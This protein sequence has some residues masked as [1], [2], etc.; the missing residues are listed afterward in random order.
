MKKTLS[1]FILSFTFCIASN[2]YAQ[3]VGIGTTAPVMRLHVQDT[4]SA[5]A[6]LE[7]T[8]PLAVDRGTALYFKTGSYYTGAI[9]TIGTGAALSRLGLF[10]Y[11]VGS[12]NSLREYLSIADNGNVGVGAIDPAYKLDINGR[13]CLRYNGNTAGAWLNKQDNSGAAVFVGNY[14]DSIFGI[15]GTTTG[16]K[17]FFDH[18][19][20]NLGINISNPKVDLSFPAATG[21]KISF[22]PGGSGDVGIGVYGNEF[23]LHS[24]HAGADITFGYDSYTAGFTERMRVK[25]NGQVCIGT[26]DPAAGY[27]LNIGGKAIAEEVR[28]QLRSAWPDY[29]F[30][31]DYSLKTLPE[32]E[33]YIQANNHLPNIPAASEVEKSGI[34][35][36]EMQTKLV[37]KVEELTLYIRSTKTNC[38]LERRQKG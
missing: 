32:L 6:L 18:K 23:R 19:N 14:S 7:N 35:L 28:V 17:F 38:S 22:Y 13:M 10:S 33:T 9:K 34:A 27:I 31:N 37:E 15:Y 25:G 5:V 21:K 16:W 36:G 12:P 26:T 3:N 30:E 11:A 29:V 1:F 4:D 8:Q 2:L 20:G 24:D